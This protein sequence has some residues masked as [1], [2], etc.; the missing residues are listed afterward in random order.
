VSY[1]VLDHTADMSVLIKAPD[2]TSL[3]SDAVKL[4]RQ[5]AVGDSPVGGDTRREIKVP[6]AAES[7][8]FFR[9]VRELIYLYDTEGFIPQRLLDRRVPLVCGEIFD[10]LRH[11]PQHQAKAVTRHRFRYDKT[12]AGYEVEMVFDL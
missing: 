10:P 11:K 9:F 12:E 8:R 6:A 4:I 3:W 1:K 2:R 5:M 7:E